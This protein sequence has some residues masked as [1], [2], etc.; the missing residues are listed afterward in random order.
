MRKEF[1]TL[2]EFAAEQL[3]NMPRSVADMERLAERESWPNTELPTRPWAGVIPSYYYKHYAPQK[4]KTNYEILRQAV[5]RAACISY[6]ETYLENECF[7]WGA[8]K[9]HDEE[10]GQPADCYYRAADELRVSRDELIAW[11]ICVRGYERSE[12]F[13]IFCLEV[14]TEMETDSEDGEVFY[15]AASNDIVVNSPDKEHS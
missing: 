7:V 2:A 10:T 13:W 1:F 6:L 4:H 5:D 15:D 12:W 8:C 3:P 9:N 14:I 11:H